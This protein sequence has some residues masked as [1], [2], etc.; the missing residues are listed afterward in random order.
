MFLPKAQDTLRPPEHAARRSFARPITDRLIVFTR[1]LR[2]LR[3]VGALHYPL[4]FDRF[5]PDCNIGHTFS[6]RD[7]HGYC[8]GAGDCL[9]YAIFLPKSGRKFL[10]IC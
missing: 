2:W 6:P 1:T 3:F 7:S 5:S 9:T 10:Q 8:S 4:A